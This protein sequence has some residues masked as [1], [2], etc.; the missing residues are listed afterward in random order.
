MPSSIKDFGFLKSVQQLINDLKQ[1]NP[2]INFIY[3]KNI[4]NQNI[5]VSEYIGLNLFRSIQQLFNNSLKHAN[6]YFNSS[7]Y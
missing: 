4:E 2:K 6:P 1:S 3:R 7:I 5:G